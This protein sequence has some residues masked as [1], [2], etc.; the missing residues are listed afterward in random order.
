MATYSE[1]QDYIR[2]KD[3]FSVKTCWI[4]DIKRSHGL[5]TRSAPNRIDPLRPTY[6]CPIEKRPSIEAAL[7]HFDML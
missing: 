4:A 6:P 2:A 5:I 7:R 1:I 3:G